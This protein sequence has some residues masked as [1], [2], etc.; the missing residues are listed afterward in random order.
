M[1]KSKALTDRVQTAVERSYYCI[2][3]WTKNIDLFEKLMLVFP[4][5]EKGHWY[6]VIVCNS[7][8]V[9]QPTQKLSID[10][11]KSLDGY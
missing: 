10:P 5:C 2:K 11:N 9:S 7:G 3:R 6:V 4:I 8:L 1:D